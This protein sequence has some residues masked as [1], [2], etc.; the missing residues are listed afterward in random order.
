MVNLL[1]NHSP[2]NAEEVEFFSLRKRELDL[3]LKHLRTIEEW[4]WQQKS[5]IKWLKEGNLNTSFFHRVASGCRRRNIITPA[6][7]PLP[8]GTFEHSLRQAV[9][10]SFMERFNQFPG[11]HIT[12]WLTSFLC[13]DSVQASNLESP[14]SEDEIL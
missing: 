11:A 8:D 12:E 6:M 7:V 5:R 10:N 4:C 14:F 9:T 3:E 1:R 13:L 2:S